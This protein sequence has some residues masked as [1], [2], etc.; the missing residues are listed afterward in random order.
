KGLRWRDRGRERGRADRIAIIRHSSYPADM[1]IRRDALALRDAGFDVDLICDAEADR[2]MLEKVDGITVCRVPPGHKRGSL[3]RYLMEYTAF[4]LTAGAAAA[5]RCLRRPYQWI[6]IN[7]MPD[8]L[9]LAALIPK[10]LGARVVLYSREDMARLFAAD[11]DLAPGHPLIR[12][13]SGLE[14]ACISM[15]DQVIVTHEMA[16]EALIKRGVPARKIVAIPNAPDEQ[17]FFAGLQTVPV[18]KVPEHRES[19]RLVTHGTLVRRYGIETLLEALAIVRHNLP[20]IHLEILGDGEYRP[21]LESLVDRLNLRPNVTFAGYLPSYGDVAP[22]L[23]QADVGV[24]AIWTDFQLCNK[25]T[26]YLALGM[27][28]ITTESAALRPYLDDNAVQF[29]EPRNAGALAR[30]ILTLH[31]DLHRRTELARQ[32]QAAY[33]EHFAWSQARSDYLSVYET[34]MEFSRNLPGITPA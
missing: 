3:L 15:A 19:F 21:E 1:H 8:W 24:V 32:G 31:W 30:A 26:D 33:R 9:L 11:H 23:L 29:V 25:L 10:L 34:Q 20:T 18:P 14:R 13:L 28:A 5:I 12:L 27:P 22:R 7:N 17:A 6:E 2:P 4:P 16:R